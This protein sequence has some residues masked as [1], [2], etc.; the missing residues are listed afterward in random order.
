MSEWLTNIWAGFAGSGPLDQVNLAL[1]VLGVWLMTRCSLWAFPVGLAAVSVQGVLFWQ[2]KFYSDAVL[3]VFFFG[4]LAYGWWHWTKGKGTAPE[5]PVTRLNWRARATGVAI[6]GAITLAWGAWLDAHTDA[7]MPFRDAFIA[8]FSLLAQIWQVRKRVE[9]WP[10]W[11]V[12]NAVAIQSYFKAD[13]AFTAFLYGVILVLGLLG[14]IEWEK[15][16]RKGGAA[17]ESAA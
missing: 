14:W 1:G 5:L 2:S 12:I 10:A 4:C 8:V 11:T 6:A 16:L 13:L 3:Q 17:K 7:P 15:A 9:N